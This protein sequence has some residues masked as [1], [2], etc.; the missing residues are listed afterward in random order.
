MQYSVFE[1]NCGYD[2]PTASDLNVL[3]E[4]GTRAK[5][6]CDFSE[7]FRRAIREVSVNLIRTLVFVMVVAGFTSGCKDLY[8]KN[9][10]KDF[11]IEHVYKQP[12]TAYGPFTVVLYTKDADYTR[13]CWNT[14]ITGRSQ[15]ELKSA[16][17]I[18]P[19]G[20]ATVKSEGNLKVRR[21]AHRGR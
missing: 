1:S 14:D 21:Q 13:T 2:P 10:K 18:N 3:V 5:R 20:S 7:S 16:L 9:I 4:E 11:G 17:V 8:T 6:S 12:S 19:L 15:D